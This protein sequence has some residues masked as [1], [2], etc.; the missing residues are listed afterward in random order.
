MALHL[1]GYV[2]MYRSGLS[3]VQTQSGDPAS[4]V[5]TVAF[6]GSAL[7]TLGA[8][9]VKVTGGWWDILSM[10]AAVNGMIV[11]T[12]SVSFV[13]NIVQTTNS[14]RIFATRYH[15]LVA[16]AGSDKRQRVLQLAPDLSAVVVKL[17]ASR[18]TGV[19]VPDDP[20]MDFPN[21][22][23]DLCDLVRSEQ[24]SD[25]S[26]LRS[27]LAL[28]GRQMRGKSGDDLEAARFW[29]QQHTIARAVVQ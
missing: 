3:L 21:S 25:M 1:V 9:T 6:A 11:L 2:V 20:V 26:E 17:T 18:L 13:L 8:S 16:G 23:L 10:I 5:Q 24:V 7:S 29:V 28:L 4:L 12:L 15:A 19:F 22:I 14:A 27:A